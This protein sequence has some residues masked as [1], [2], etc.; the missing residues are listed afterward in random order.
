MDLNLITYIRYMVGVD[1]M[2]RLK[3]LCKND[4]VLIYEDNKLKINNDIIFSFKNN[5]LRIKSE[6]EIIKEA[7]EKL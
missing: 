4:D 1:L 7:Y 5:I 6:S 2:P 3:D